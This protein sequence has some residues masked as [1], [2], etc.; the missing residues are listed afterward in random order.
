MC[1]LDSTGSPQCWGNRYTREGIE[2]MEGL[3]AASHQSVGLFCGLT[4]AADMHCVD[5]EWPGYA[6]RGVLILAGP[7]QSVHTAMTGGDTHLFH[8]GL[9]A[10]G[11]LECGGTYRR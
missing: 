2:E 1:A 6:P 4:R 8:C 5:L 9:R 3:F 10:D 7:Y 11:A